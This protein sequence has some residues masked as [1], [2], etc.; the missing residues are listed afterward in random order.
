MK[1]L[2]PLLLVILCGAGVSPRVRDFAQS[3]V[4]ATAV[5]AASDDTF[6]RV[7]TV[8]VPGLRT[9]GLSPDGHYVGVL[10]QSAPTAAHQKVSLWRWSDRPTS[11]L[12]TRAEHGITQV[13]VSREGQYVLTW[14]SM[15][16]TQRLLSLR[17]GT[18]GVCLLPLAVDGAIWNVQTAG[19]GLSAAIS[20]GAHSVYLMTL[21]DRPVLH[22]W[23]VA[24]LGAGNSLSFSPDSSA[25]AVATWDETS[26]SRYTSRGALVW[27]YPVRAQSRKMLAGRIFETQ[28]TRN[29]K[30]I[31]GVSY[32]NVRRE[33]AHL[34]LWQCAGNGAPAWTYALGPDASHPR[35]LASA[36][37]RYVVAGYTEI[38]MRG[39]QSLPERRMA[40]L[41]TSQNK[42][43]WEEGNLLF[44]P[45][46]VALSPN[47][48]RITV[49]DGQHS[50]YNLN[51][52]GRVTA[53]YILRG[54]GHIKQITASPDGKYILV[55]TSDGVLSLLQTG[56]DT[57]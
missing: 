8:S 15:D 6:K 23:P 10:F 34:Y 9:F 38:I 47:G 24:L 53:N 16:T 44:S 35:A 48:A 11:P 43:I 39:E 30:G 51:M 46:L 50:L 41:D 42:L 25:L 14:A 40:L 29:G 32:T 56:S 36:D 57:N 17:R 27:Q 49:S 26:I 52:E 22:R 3:L 12:W 45:Q 33:D 54:T 55:Y 5:E 4:P 28:T 13:A 19:D 1:K 31:L 2:W 20:S 37:G 7:W 18:D 21:D